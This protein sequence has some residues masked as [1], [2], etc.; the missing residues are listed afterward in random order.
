MEVYILKGEEGGQLEYQDFEKSQ[1]PPKEGMTS[2]T[3][4]IVTN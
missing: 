2:G 3:D 1:M 4:I